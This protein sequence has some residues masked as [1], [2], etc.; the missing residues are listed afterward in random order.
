MKGHNH[1]AA[2]PLFDRIVFDKVVTFVNVNS[3]PQFDSIVLFFLAN[4]DLVLQLD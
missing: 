2:S 1:E 3:Q 4:R